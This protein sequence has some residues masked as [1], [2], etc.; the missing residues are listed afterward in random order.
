VRQAVVA[1]YGEGTD[2]RLVAWLLATHPAAAPA[3]GALRA[4]LAASLPAYMVPS[5]FI[6]LDAFPLTPNGKL[7]R[8]ALPAP[9]QS[10]LTARAY[11]A[12]QGKTE[13]MVARLWQELLNVPQVGRDDHFFELGGHSL[14]ALQFTVNVS[15]E[16]NVEV[17]LKTVFEHPVLAQLSGVL[18]AL[19]L[20]TYAREDVA[21]LEADFADWTEEQL[22][23]LLSGDAQA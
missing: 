10:S 19:Q 21:A 23:A 2:K 18:D 12:P 14:L 22:L 15:K 1:A 20:S 3:P 7:D 13:G 6:V 11:A 17:S 5:A 8:K 4:A 16:L 9:D